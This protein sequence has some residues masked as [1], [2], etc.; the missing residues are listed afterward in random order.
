MPKARHRVST[1]IRSRDLIA[2]SVARPS[3]A[4]TGEWELVTV[5]RGECVQQGVPE[6]PL[7]T[8]HDVRVLGLRVEAVRLELS[9]QGDGDAPV[10]LVHV[11]KRLKAY[12][13]RVATRR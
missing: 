7:G 8:L 1:V 2:F 11:Y 10:E 13:I 9:L 12:G 5:Q 6:L 4:L 3:I